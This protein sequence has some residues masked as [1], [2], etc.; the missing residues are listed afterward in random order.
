[1]D[2]DKPL[3]VVLAYYRCP[4]L[5]SLVLRG[6]DKAIAGMT[7][8]VGKD[9]RVLVV[10]FDTRDTTEVAHD[11]RA[12][13]LGELASTTKKSSFTDLDVGS[14]EF[15]TASESDV[16]RIADAIGFHYK[17]DES[18]QQYAHAAGLFVITPKGKLSQ[19]FTGIEFDADEVDRAVGEAYKEVWHSPIKSTL[20]YC[21]NYDPKTGHYVPIVM[22]VMKVGAALTILIVG[23]F[24]YRLFRAERKRPE[25]PAIADGG[26]DA[27]LV[28]AESA[29][30]K[31]LS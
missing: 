26:S 3:L 5:C 19:T 31:G 20:L 8:E 23:F 18:Q 24:V 6:M 2:G 17:W 10:S 7:H 1:M 14:Y 13:Y 29:P 15:A 30:S 27:P 16:K 25:G 28:A 9:Y 11:K 4:M 12:N 21:F 22:N